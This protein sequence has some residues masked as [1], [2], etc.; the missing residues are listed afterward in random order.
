MAAVDQL[1][2]LVVIRREGQVVVDL[3]RRIRDQTEGAVGVGLGQR[4]ARPGEGA[5]E[6]GE[7]ASGA[8]PSSVWAKRRPSRR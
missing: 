1:A 4:V 8:S 7:G 5:A 3:L 2:G 6:A